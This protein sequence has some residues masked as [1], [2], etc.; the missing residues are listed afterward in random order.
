LAVESQR[1][2]CV[3]DRRFRSLDSPAYRLFTGASAP[4]AA[5]RLLQLSDPRAH[6]TDAPDLTT[7]C[8]SRSRRGSQQRCPLRNTANR[9][10]TGQGSNPFRTGT[11]PPPRRPLTAVDLPQPDRPGHLLSPTRAALD[12]EWIEDNDRAVTASKTRTS[13]PELPAPKNGSLTRAAS[14]ASSRKSTR[15]A[16]PEVPSTPGLH[17]CGWSAYC[18]GR[19]VITS[20]FAVGQRLFAPASI[21]P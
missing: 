18:G 15:S 10:F 21:P 20:G 1:P 12:L 17:P 19:C 8:D 2:T 14:P 5:C 9:A 16:A 3:H 4:H 11:Q 7:R 6:R 13:Q